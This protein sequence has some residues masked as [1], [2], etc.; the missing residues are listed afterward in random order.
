M[1]KGIA[2]ELEFAGRGRALSTLFHHLQRMYEK[3]ISFP[4]QI[5]LK[6]HHSTQKT[7]FLCEKKDTRGLYSFCKR[8][9]SDPVITYSLCFSSTDF[10][11]ISKVPNPSLE[12]YGLEVLEQSKLF[13]PIYP[14]PGGYRKNPLEALQDFLLHPF[15]KGKIPRE[16]LENLTW[17]ETDWKIF[18]LMNANIREK[19][20]I[21]GRKTDND[22][23][24]VKSRFYRHILPCC[25]QIN[26]FFPKGFNSY[27]PVFLKLESEY[28]SS[29]VSALKNLSTTSYVFPLEESL[30]L[31][32]FFYP[33][34]NIVGILKAIEKLEEMAIVTNHLFYSPIISIE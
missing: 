10:F 18:N 16:V 34:E 22:S 31:V 21:V 12:K 15:Q 19:F 1:P 14:I 13:T 25:I 24:T 29:I 2:K 6:A 32:L 3:K 26:Y 17:D 8:L 33:T 20:T 9:E 5:T 4:P 23:K 30:V 7:V 28:E 11:L 27:S